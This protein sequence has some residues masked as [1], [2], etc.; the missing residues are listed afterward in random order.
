MSQSDE[1]V[2]VGDFLGVVEEYIPGFGTYE[3]DGKI[4][5]SFV[6]YKRVDR[7]RLEISIEPA[8]KKEI[9]V[10]QIGDVVICEVVMARKQSAMV[11]IFKI[12]NHFLFDTYPGMVHVSNM[13]Q[14]TLTTSKRDSAR[15]T[16]YERRSSARISRNTSSRQNTLS[17]VASIANAYR[18]VQCFNVMATNSCATR[19]DFQILERS[20]RITATCASA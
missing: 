4:F 7:Q 16:S 13:S 5:S 8:K 20:R 3:S 19:A 10:P 9:I 1:I 11:H 18:V 12:R 2:A 6:G 14:N 17:S 15:P